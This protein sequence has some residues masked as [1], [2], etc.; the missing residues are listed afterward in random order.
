MLKEEMS[1][2]GDRGSN[3]PNKDNHNNVKTSKKKN[4]SSN[5]K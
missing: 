5:G 2:L 1:I 4:S 3:V